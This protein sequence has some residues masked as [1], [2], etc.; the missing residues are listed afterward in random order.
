MPR[1]T[2]VSCRNHSCTVC[3]FILLPRYLLLYYSNNLF[4]RYGN[5]GLVRL[6]QIILEIVPANQSL[7]K[8]E[9]QSGQEAFRPTNPAQTNKTLF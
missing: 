9:K 8:L 1:W 6:C 2:H 7:Y 3:R 4:D 5:L